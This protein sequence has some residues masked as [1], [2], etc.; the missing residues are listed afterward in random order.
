MRKYLN[1]KIMMLFVCLIVG[2]QAI[3]GTGLEVAAAVPPV[4]DEAGLLSEEERED[5]MEQVTALKE[6][7]GWDIFAVTTANANGKTAAAYADDFYDAQ[8]EVDSNGI[9]VLI[10]MDNREICISTAGEAIRYLDDMRIE[11]ILDDAYYY[12]SE[13]DYSGCLSV[14]LRGAENYYDA[15]IHEDQ[16]NYDVETGAVS[17]YHKITWMEAVPVLLLSVGVGVGIYLFVVKS[18]SVKGGRD[19]YAYTQY[20]KVDLTDFDDRF[21][22]QTVIHQRIQTNS[23][24]GSSRSS[25]G[26]SHRSSVHRSSSGRSHGGG[27][28]RF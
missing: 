14:M 3:S 12:V 23:G 22:N 26:G 11:A 4:Y 5:L 13:G 27:S 17:H 21:V 7:T 18:Y 10:D 1:V 16:Y 20:G 24:G 6:K 9:L 15:G 8:T 28:R 2:I 25:G 19:S